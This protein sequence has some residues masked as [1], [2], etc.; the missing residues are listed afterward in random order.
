MAPSGEDLLAKLARTRSL[1]DP[2][3]L[4]DIAG[5][6]ESQ[7]NADGGFRG[8]DE[9]SDLYYTYFATAC[10]QALGRQPLS[11]ATATYIQGFGNGDGLD[12]VHL[13]CLAQCLACAVEDGRRVS[14]EP[15]LSK[16]EAY[17]AADGGYSPAPAAR[18]G[19]AYACYLAWLAYERWTRRLPKPEAVARC[20]ESLKVTGGGYANAH[21][22][23]TGIVTASAAAGVVLNALASVAS[24]TDPDTTATAGT[25]PS[26]SKWLLACDAEG[27]GLKAA[28][29]SPVP[30]LLSTATGLFA[31]QTLKADIGRIG[32]A[33]VA[34]VQSLWQNNG[35]FS[36][37]PLDVTTDAEYTYYGL[38]A[39]S[40]LED[41]V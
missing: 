22:A 41:Y 2:D 7:R 11:P 39:L 14:I 9:N 20:L 27:G 34:F 5:F 28:A 24:G 15:V 40:C 10:L 26:L 4:D 8:R 3:A 18:H 32:P 1:L 25:D 12:L 36:A 17:R 16:L 13:C 33:C 29:N 19:T 30:D 35:G 37:Q 23:E 6:V 31:L 38:L 21:G